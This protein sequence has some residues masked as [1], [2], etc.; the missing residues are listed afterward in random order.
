M[1]LL[2]NYYNLL[3]NNL[4]SNEFLSI[5]YVYSKNLIPVLMLLCTAKFHFIKIE[6]C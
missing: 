4:F 3:L 6:N 1:Q 5:I 2:I